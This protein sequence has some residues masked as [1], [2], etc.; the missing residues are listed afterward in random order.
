MMK[1]RVTTTAAKTGFDK[2]AK[3]LG[4]TSWSGYLV[5]EVN[6]TPWGNVTIPFDKYLLG[7]YILDTTL[8]VRDILEE[9]KMMDINSLE[10]PGI[11]K[12][13]SK[14]S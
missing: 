9:D 5:P 11:Q 2:E 12:A 3:S 7:L 6:F 13:L 4:S 14:S 1:A 8:F 10:I